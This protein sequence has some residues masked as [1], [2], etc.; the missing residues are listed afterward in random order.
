MQICKNQN[1][2]FILKS[3]IVFGLL[4]T[5]FSIIGIFL[6]DA[7]APDNPLDSVSVEHVIG[8]IVWGM[9]AGLASLSIRYFFLTGIFAI[10]L[11]SDHLVNFIGQDIVSRMGHSIPFAIMAMVTM[12]LFAKRDYKLG[13][14]SA[15]AVFAHISFDTLYARGSEFPLYIPI[16]AGTVHF[17]ATDWIW[18]QLIAIAIVASS[19]LYTMFEKKRQ[20]NI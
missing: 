12:T 4:S 1:A 5:A 16:D 9:I 7:T 15:A 17:N 2:K 20:Q 10:V 11:D 13:A 14:I 19:T 6:P 18:L 3:T 8:H